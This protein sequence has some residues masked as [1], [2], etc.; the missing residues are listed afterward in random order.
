MTKERMGQVQLRIMK[1]LWKLE[2]ATA[3]ELTDELN[4]TEP[5]AHST[6]QTLLRQLEAKGSVNHEQEGR[7]FY[8]FPC[9]K[10]DKVKRSASRDLI[11]N[12]F[13]GNAGGLVSYLLETERISADELAQIREQIDQKRKK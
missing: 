6:V 5:I 7:T 4:K 1:L 10:E 9:V 11:E 8:F 3:R 2:R 13:G 12:I